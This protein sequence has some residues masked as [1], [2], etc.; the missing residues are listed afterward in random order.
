MAEPTV[1]RPPIESCLGRTC[2]AWADD[3]ELSS[4][5]FDLVMERL[6]RVDQDVAALRQPSQQL[7]P[8]PSLS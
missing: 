7:E 1:K 3:G 6:A 8:C 4:L 2:L 5:D